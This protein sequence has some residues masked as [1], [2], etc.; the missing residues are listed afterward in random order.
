MTFLERTRKLVENLF[1]KISQEV[2][3]GTEGGDNFGNRIADT[4]KKRVCPSAIS[5]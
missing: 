4:G 3:E 1:S 5:A 2:A